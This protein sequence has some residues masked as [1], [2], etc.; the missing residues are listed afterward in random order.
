MA[1][2]PNSKSLA[3]HSAKLVPNSKTHSAKLVPYS[4]PYF[5][6]SAKLI[7]KKKEPFSVIYFF[8]QTEF[9]KDFI[10]CGTF[11]SQLLFV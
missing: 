3:F 9:G 1:K 4:I 11:D 2:W 6:H 10:F 8:I 5:C 7:G